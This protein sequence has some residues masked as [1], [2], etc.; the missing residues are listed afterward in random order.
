[1]PCILVRI[2]DNPVCFS[3]C[4]STT[5]VPAGQ[6][7]PWP[8]RGGGFVVGS[9]KEVGGVLCGSTPEDT[10]SS[11]AIRDESRSSTRV[12]RLSLRGCVRATVV[13]A[14]PRDGPASPVALFL[15]LIPFHS[16]M[17]RTRPTS[18][19]PSCYQRSVCA[20]SFL[21]PREAHCSRLRRRAITP[22]IRL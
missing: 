18:L 6:T 1:M 22:V 14:N 19:P 3:G 8:C 11:G 10:V 5:H 20:P 17:R 16:P 9:G 15:S 4:L 2:L 13:G 21:A 7:F 12:L